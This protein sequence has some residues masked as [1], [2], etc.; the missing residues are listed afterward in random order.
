MKMKSKNWTGGIPVS[1]DYVEVNFIRHIEDC[2]PQLRKVDTITFTLKQWAAFKL[3][4]D[5]LLYYLHYN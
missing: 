3:E 1:K 5:H 2:D 4:M